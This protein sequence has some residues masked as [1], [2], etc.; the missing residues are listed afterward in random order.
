M[1]FIFLELRWQPGV[2]FVALLRGK[3]IAIS[4]TNAEIMSRGDE[5]S[6]E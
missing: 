6:Y 3:Y 4:E 5:F 2:M 1:F